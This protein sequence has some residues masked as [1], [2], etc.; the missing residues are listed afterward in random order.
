[1]TTQLGP[2]DVLTLLTAV[3]K[4][5]GRDASSDVALLYGKLMYLEQELSRYDST[6]QVYCI[7]QAHSVPPA[8][9]PF[10]TGSVPP[11]PAPVTDAQP[12]G[13]SEGIPNAGSAGVKAL[14][15]AAKAFCDKVDAG[16]ARSI[17]SY[18]QF[19]NALYLIDHAQ[20]QS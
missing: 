13:K 9:F 20:D 3:T 16:Q 17:V 19:K 1:M 8:P 14:I 10:G 2:K 12:L 7:V 4:L 5:P 6:A 11:A 18:T 15:M